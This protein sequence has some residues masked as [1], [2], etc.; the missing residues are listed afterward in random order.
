MLTLNLNPFT[1]L[2]I[3]KTILTDLKTDLTYYMFKVTIPKVIKFP[4]KMSIFRFFLNIFLRLNN[5]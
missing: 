4:A 5:N 1:A 2:K 3:F